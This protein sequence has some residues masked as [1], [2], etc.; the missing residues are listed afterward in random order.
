[1]RE[2][3]AAHENRVTSYLALASPDEPLPDDAERAPPEIVVE[4]ERL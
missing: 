2:I 3:E 1:M 4:R